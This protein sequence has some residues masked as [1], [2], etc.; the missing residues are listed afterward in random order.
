[1][2]DIKH[3]VYFM[4]E[5]NLIKV[6]WTVT[7][8]LPYLAFSSNGLLLRIPKVTSYLKFNECL[9]EKVPQPHCFVDMMETSV[10]GQ[11]RTDRHEKAFQ[12]TTKE[13]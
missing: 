6:N 1:M 4:N 13:L 12:N 5:S 7:T 8:W 10:G 9:W 11:V 3:K 2:F